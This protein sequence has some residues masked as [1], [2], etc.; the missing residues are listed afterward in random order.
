MTYEMRTPTI[1]LDE[2]ELRSLRRWLNQFATV[3]GRDIFLQRAPLDFARPAYVLKEI[4]RRPLD[5]G[6]SMTAEETDWQLEILTTDFWDT[7]RE[8]S[9]IRQRLLQSLRVPLY[10]WSWQFPPA[11]VEELSGQGSLP[12]GEVSVRVSAVSHDSEE[13]LASTAVAVTVASGSA[14]RVSWTPWPRGATVA[15]EYRV[16]AGASGAETLEQTII[17]PGDGL[18]LFSDLTALA[19]GGSTP[20]ASSVFFANRY[21][22][23]EPEQVSSRIMEHPSADDVF[24]GY[25]T[26]R[27]CVESVRIAR[28]G[29]TPKPAVG[30]V[31][32]TLEVN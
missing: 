6:R 30:S 18:P 26:F 11:T 9:E 10:L 20:P 19:G 15:K 2:H 3:N 23:I 29:D 22:R 28:P 27:T 32:T 8:T 17:D 24:N 21:L 14:V 5:R 12:A 31:T 13:S 16:Y 4:D 7:K 1:A 25:V